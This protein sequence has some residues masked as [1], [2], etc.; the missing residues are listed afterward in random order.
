MIIMEA[1]DRRSSVRAQIG[2]KTPDEILSLADE[3]YD[4][5]PEH[6]SWLRTVAERLRQSG[7]LTLADVTDDEF[8]AIVA[9]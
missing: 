7:Y 1:V 2:R 5:K 8:D 4:F 6:V 3:R 9:E